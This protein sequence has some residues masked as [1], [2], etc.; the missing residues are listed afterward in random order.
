MRPRAAALLLALAAPLSGIAQPS[1]DPQ[2]DPENAIEATLIDPLH[3]AL[4]DMKRTRPN[5]RCHKVLV[6]RTSEGIQVDFLAQFEERL[7]NDGAVVFSAQPTCRGMS[8]VFDPDG[9]RIVRRI[10]S[11]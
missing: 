10:Y 6:Y 9:K 8:Y 1:D 11:R 7:T 4:G 2:P 5:W 3:L